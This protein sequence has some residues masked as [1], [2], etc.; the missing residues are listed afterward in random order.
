MSCHQLEEP[1][2]EPLA[3]SEDCRMVSVRTGSHT[4]KSSLNWTLNC[5]EWPH[6]TG[7]T[8]LWEPAVV[9][10]PKPQVPWCFLQCH[11][12][13]VLLSV[14]STDG[15]WATLLSVIVFNFLLFCRQVTSLWSIFWVWRMLSLQGC[16]FLIFQHAHLFPFVN[17]Q[18]TQLCPYKTLKI[19]TT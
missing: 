8:L 7:W 9:Y 13:S 10:F 2:A 18:H 16:L 6:Y 4:F 11:S 12:Q 19:S 3:W 1:L 15:N 14:S 17:F 5:P